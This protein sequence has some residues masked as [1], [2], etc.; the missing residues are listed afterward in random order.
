MGWAIIKEYKSDYFQ[1]I[2]GVFEKSPHPV[3]CQPF[4]ADMASVEWNKLIQEIL[5][6]KTVFQAIDS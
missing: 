2:S 4:L 5:A 6:R 1:I 3:W